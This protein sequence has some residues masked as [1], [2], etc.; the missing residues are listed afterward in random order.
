MGEVIVAHCVD[1]EG[2]LEE[3]LEET[4]DRL[5][6]ICGIELTPSFDTLVKIQNKQLN[7]NGKEKQAFNLVSPARVNTNK[8]WDQISEMIDHICSDKFREKHSDSQGLPWKYSWFVLD[9]VGFSGINPR[10]RDIRHHAVFNY[11]TSSSFTVPKGDF[12]GWHYHP[13]PIN[14]NLHCSGNTFLNSSNIT[15]I[16][17]RKIIDKCWFPAVFRPGFHTERPDISWFLEQWIPFDYGNQAIESSAPI[18]GDL[19]GSRFGDW[20]RAPRSWVP[21]H[22]DHS[23]YQTHGAC[24]RLIARCLNMKARLRE[25]SQSDVDDAFIEAAEKGKSLLSFTN[26]DFRNMAPEIT[27]VYDFIQNANSKFPSIKV[28][29]ANALEAFRLMTGRFPQSPDLS[30]KIVKVD[31]DSY[32]LCA[33]T[34][35]SLF[36]PQ[37]YLAIRTVDGDYIWKNF[38]FEDLNSWSFT[39]DWQ[40]ID[41]HHCSHIGVAAPTKSGCIDIFHH[42]VFY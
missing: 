24:N 14:G 35:S 2:P 41:Y 6:N 30:C 22:P 9:H 8:D 32:R 28:T 31:N 38:D 7:L 5:K 36:G 29:H 37:P 16:L 26:H 34:V 25:I 42:S 12:I 4:F 19:A 15:E 27:R 17:A 18:H 39:F 33:R 20:H 1:T 11:Y 3:T 23:D 21:Y 13:L 10:N 40:D